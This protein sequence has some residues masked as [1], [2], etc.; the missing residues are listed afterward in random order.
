[1]AKFETYPK[2]P[3][4]PETG[5]HYDVFGYTEFVDYCLHTPRHKDAESASEKDQ[6]GDENPWSGTQTFEEAVKFAKHGWDAGLK[7]LK[8]Y[9][10]TDAAKISVSHDLVGH[11]VDV[12]RF[13]TGVPDTMVSFHDESFRDKTPI[14]IYTR[15]AYNAGFSGKD[16]MEYCGKILDTIALLSRTFN[17]KLVGVFT[18]KHYKT[19]VDMVMVN[20]KDTDERFVMNN[21]A[22][23][24]NPA[25]FRRF[26]FKW[27][28]TTNFFQNGYGQGMDNKMG[29]GK[30]AKLL[31]KI[32]PPQEQVLFMP[33]INRRK[34]IDPVE[35]TKKAVEEQHK[36]R[37]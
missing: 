20:I 17:V 37:G 24:Y 15:L 29:E 1:M 32:L 10:E 11:A 34:E 36:R 18:T 6:T 22:F 25:F 9:V 21:L 33:E 5:I 3:Y 12:G 35:I 30:E 28:E 23:A 2:M 19:G 27:F 14:T 8:D 26:W 4:D 31:T 16:A 13:L 7:D